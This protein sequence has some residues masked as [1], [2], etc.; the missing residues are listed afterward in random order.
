MRL[1]FTNKFQSE[2]IHDSCQISISY[3]CVMLEKNRCPHKL[4][5][6]GRTQLRESIESSEAE[7]KLQPAIERPARPPLL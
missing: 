6:P 4:Q 2:E 1:P 3:W 5:D 7:A